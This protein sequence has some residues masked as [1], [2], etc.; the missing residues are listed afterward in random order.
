MCFPTEQQTLQ[1]PG[2]FCIQKS[3]SSVE[4]EEET[5][6]PLPEKRLLKPHRLPTDFIFSK[7][8]LKQLN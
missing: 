1:P 5:M 6:L 4:I 8:F 2:C 7:I 3:R